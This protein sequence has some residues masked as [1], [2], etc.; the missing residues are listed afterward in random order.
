MEKNQIINVY[1]DLRAA[2]DSVDRRILWTYL[3]KK[4]GMPLNLVK[5]LRAFFDYNESSHSIKGRM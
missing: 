5:L 2:Y 4:F 3:A 1:M